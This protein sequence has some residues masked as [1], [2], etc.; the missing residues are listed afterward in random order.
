MKK[1]KMMKKRTRLM[2]RKKKKKRRA[3]RRT[4]KRT[5]KMKMTTRTTIFVQFVKTLESYYAVIPVASPFILN[6][7]THR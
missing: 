1:T 5:S 6:A 3:L 2:T 4:T 7:T